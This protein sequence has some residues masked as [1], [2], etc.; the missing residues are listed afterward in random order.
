MGIMKEPCE[1]CPYRYDIRKYLTPARGEELA[2]HARNPYNSFPCH[3]TTVSSE[4]YGCDDG[5]LIRTDKSKECAGFLTLQINEGAPI[6]KSFEP[7]D[8]IYGS[9][10]DMANSY[11]D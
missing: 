2:Y 1:H 3:K 7:S 8:K 5:E 6:P 4:I 9:S 11:N 10:E